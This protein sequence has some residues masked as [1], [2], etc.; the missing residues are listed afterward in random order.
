MDVLPFDSSLGS[1]P[2]WEASAS[3]PE[4]T[5]AV[6]SSGCTLVASPKHEPSNL[7][8]IAYLGADAGPQK[9]G[10]AANAAAAAQVPQ[11]AARGP[12]H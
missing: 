10:P 9:E 2:G 12:H 3:G 1:P 5:L 6:S 8:K 7:D 4:G 11:P